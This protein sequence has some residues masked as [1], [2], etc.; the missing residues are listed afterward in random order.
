MAKSRISEQSII[1]LFEV[2]NGEL[3]PTRHCYALSFLKVIM[4]NFPDDYMDIYKYLFYM[5]C[6]DPVNNPYIN[7]NDII[8]EEKIIRDNQFKFSTE[9][10][11][12][13]IALEK[14]TRLYETPTVRMFNTLKDTIDNLQD[15]V[16]QTQFTSGKGGSVTEI[17]SVIK[18]FDKLNEQFNA[19]AGR[20]HEEQK[21]FGKRGGG[22]L[23]YD[24]GPDSTRDDD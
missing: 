6:P 7:M 3:K 17:M 12:I 10:D 22:Q 5:T 16:G 21:N 2:D 19:A 13:I 14:C 24:M 15:W 20:V 4:D 8:R 1:H 11:S 9:E 23:A 18:N